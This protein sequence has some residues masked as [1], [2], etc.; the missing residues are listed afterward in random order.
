MTNNLTKYETKYD[1]LEKGRAPVI[2][3]ENGSS[4]FNLSVVCFV[5]DFNQHTSPECAVKTVSE[6]SNVSV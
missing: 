6:H 1:D 5:T 2:S 3:L 4:N